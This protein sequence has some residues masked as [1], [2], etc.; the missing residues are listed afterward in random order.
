MTYYINDSKI[1]AELSQIDSDI[2]EA[3]W[4]VSEKTKELGTLDTLRKELCKLLNEAEEVIEES[5]VSVDKVKRG[6]NKVSIKIAY[7]KLKDATMR[8]VDI[9]MEMS[10]VLKDLQKTTSELMTVENQLKVLQD[11]RVVMRKQLDIMVQAQE[12]YLSAVHMYE[13]INKKNAN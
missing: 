8:R 9:D 5:Q 6:Q 3:G 12:A 10:K 11:T 13:L 4:V 7:D 1:L 2:K